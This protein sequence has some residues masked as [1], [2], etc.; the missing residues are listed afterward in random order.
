MIALLVSALAPAVLLVW[1]FRARDVYPEPARVVWT[2]FALGFV[3]VVPVLIVGIPMEFL[4]GSI[5]SPMLY[6]LASAFLVAAIPEELFKYLVL[7]GYSMRQ[8]AFDEPMDGVV[9]G[10]TAS[11]GF[12]ALENILY[13]ADGGVGVA[14]LRA[15]TAVP[16]HACLGAIMG[17]YMGRARVAPPEQA[18]RLV[19]RALVIP[20]VLHG[21]YD[22]PLLAAERAEEMALDSTL[23]IALL[24]SVLVVLLLEFVWAIRLVRLH[25]REQFG[26]MK[27]A[28]VAAD[29]ETAARPPVAAAGRVLALCLTGAGAGLVLLGSLILLLVSIGVVVD[30]EPVGELIGIAIGTVIIAGLPLMVGA[31]LFRLGVRRMNRVAEVDAG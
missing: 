30:P 27:K 2:T 6:G 4:V 22:F 16:G 25:R 19:S 17:S 14:L 23:A 7:R 26:A 21:L 28:D 31:W 13:V 15:L 18:R 8:D 3:I 29:A 11:L 9:Y 1:Y 20:I 24:P 5:A 12:A 10:A